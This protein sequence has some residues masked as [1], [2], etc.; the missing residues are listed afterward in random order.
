M[1]PYLRSYEF[2]VLAKNH[3]KMRSEAARANRKP[4]TVGTPDQIWRK[5]IAVKDR[6]IQDANCM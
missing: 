4:V 1:T 5:Q 3:R 6:S 2:R